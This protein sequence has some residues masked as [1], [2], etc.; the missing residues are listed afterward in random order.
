MAKLEFKGGY[1]LEFAIDS[2]NE[3]KAL[4]IL[5]EIFGEKIKREIKFYGVAKRSGLVFISHRFAENELTDENYG[6]LLDHKDTLLI[7][8]DELSAKRAGELIQICI[9]V[10][11]LLKRLL[12]Y[13]WSEIY[14]VLGM[15][16]DE[17]VKIEICRQTYSLYLGKLVPLLEADLTTKNREQLFSDG[18]KNII[19]ILE[20]SKD[21][22]DLKS[23]LMVF[24][25]PHTVWEQISV[26]LRKPVPY[27]EFS[28]QLK[29]LKILRDKAAHPQVILAKDINDARD[30]SKHILSKIGEVRNDYYDDL[31]KSISKLT[32]TM[33][34]T[35]AKFTEIN[36]TK[37]I[38]ETTAALS[39]TLSR[40]IAEAT[41]IPP[42]RFDFSRFVSGIDW[43]TVS[44]EMKANDPEMKQ[45]LEDFEENGSKATIDRMNK[46]LEEDIK[47]IKKPDRSKRKKKTKR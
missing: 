22:D 43:N 3:F 9:P 42:A 45:I 41:R 28:K 12:I 11:T 16:K 30:Y 29:R 20:E 36:M 5:A 19:N 39:E 21:F 25:K 27:S 6:K 44:S 24:T 4:N 40:T 38:A 14:A 32:S 2:E 17:K 37:I 13:V 23:K 46:E 47:K 26:M 1:Q 34:E 7:I 33:T 15:D 18:G 35:M 8:N 10:E 31:A